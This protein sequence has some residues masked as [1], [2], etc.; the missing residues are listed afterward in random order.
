[1]EKAI[2]T[3]AVG[4]PFYCPFCGA[5]TL[6]P[7]VEDKVAGFK[8]CQH[9]LY[10]GTTEGG[11][12]YINEIYSEQITDEM[13]EEELIDVEIHDAIHFSL[14]DPTPSLIRV[15]AG[16]KLKPPS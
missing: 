16:F 1:M 12:E 13:G 11:F 10:I 14:C 8:K 9:L 3:H 15:Y 7:Y 2:I 5:Q 4:T 6:P